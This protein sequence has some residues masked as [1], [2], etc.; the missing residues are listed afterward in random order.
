MWEEVL[1]VP[2]EE[3]A[4]VEPD[5]EGVVGADGRGKVDVHVDIEGWGVERGRGTGSVNHCQAG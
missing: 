5:E 2:L 4:A 1:L 3:S